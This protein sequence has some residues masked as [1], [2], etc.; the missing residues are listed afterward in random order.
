MKG[1]F[2]SPKS[3]SQLQRA[4]LRL[5]EAKMKPPFL[6]N[7]QSKDNREIQPVITL[8]PI[9]YTRSQDPAKAEK[10]M[11]FMGLRLQGVRNSDDDSPINSQ[12][13][14]PLRNSAV[15]SRL[16]SFSSEA[17]KPLTSLG[18]VKSFNDSDGSISENEEDEGQSGSERREYNRGDLSRVSEEVMNTSQASPA[19]FWTSEQPEKVSVSGF[20]HSKE[21]TSIVL[22]G[23]PKEDHYNKPSILLPSDPSIIL[24]EDL[25]MGSK[26]ASSE[27]IELDSEKEESNK[28]PSIDLDYPKK[29]EPE[30]QKMKTSGIGGGKKDSSSK[31]IPSPSRPARTKG[32]Q[33][34]KTLESI[35]SFAQ[36]CTAQQ[37]VVTKAFAGDLRTL[38]GIL[39][40]EYQM[41]LR[42][43]ALTSDQVPENQ[44][45]QANTQKLI[46][47]QD[48]TKAPNK[49]N[50]KNNYLP[51]L[52]ATS[53]VYMEDFFQE[54][55][56]HENQQDVPESLFLV[57]T[58]LER[59]YHSDSQVKQIRIPVKIQP[60]IG[61]ND[62]E[63]LKMISRGAFGR[64]WL[65]KRKATNDLYAMKVIDLTEKFLKNNKELE[66]LRKEN[67]VFGLAQEDFVVRA[68]FTFT[69]QTCI[70][71]VM[72]YM[73]GGDFGDILYNYCALE[74]DVA[75]FYLAEI[76][77]A[78]EY[79]HSLGIVH[80]DLKPDN[81][82][83]DKNGH[84]KLTDFGLSETGLSQKMKTG[85]SYV[86]ANAYQGKIQEINQ[87][88]AKMNTLGNHINLKLNGK[89]MEKRHDSLEKGEEIIETTSK[90][91]LPS[92]RDSSPKK[93]NSNK[94][95]P[96]LIG[97]PDYMAP[98]II[99]GASVTSYSIDWWSLGVILFEFLVGVPPFNDS[100]P[101]KIY[102]N[103]VNL[104]IPWNELSI[105][106][107]F[108]LNIN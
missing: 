18:T 92:P 31:E 103:I 49:L 77:L 68:V 13:Q 78:V 55:Q 56:E 6:T 54:H 94:R 76:V 102:D 57:D 85:H 28:D 5:K 1:T 32:L 7:L 42:N 24:H 25:K 46:I 47:V 36:F 93:R 53:N 61:M 106:N 34:Q 72:E 51:S 41:K 27:S 69:F 2:V 16:H 99:L 4:S 97:T 71:F 29:P 45:N 98:E 9:L 86:E 84:A 73:I 50:E 64:V 20:Y 70:C 90:D 40:L 82:L 66:N 88:C 83:L 44:D 26:E 11:K 75:R 100:S 8:N 21:P 37:A 87:L 15:K 80:R 91:S 67:K 23:V 79:L 39:D 14:S 38:T 105:G 17:N 101:D 48:S 22:E 89:I 19:R 108:K 74:E 35:P 10:A 52:R 3:M 96:R 30:Y 81:I 62:F 33:K 63:P 107:F 104:R 12:T 58:V 95:H 43:R 59:G 60:L 65:V